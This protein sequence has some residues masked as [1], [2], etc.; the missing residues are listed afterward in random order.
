MGGGPKEKAD[1]L[2]NDEEQRETHQVS[3]WPLWCMWKVEDLE[4]SSQVHYCKL[5]LNLSAVKWPLNKSITPLTL[6]VIVSIY[7]IVQAS[8]VVRKKR[9]LIVLL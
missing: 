3:F 9:F 2:W 5:E 6:D 7:N 4:E 1:S 8:Y